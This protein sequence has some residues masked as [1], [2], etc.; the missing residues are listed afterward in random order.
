VIYQDSGIIPQ[1]VKQPVQV[2]VDWLEVGGLDPLGWVTRWCET[3]GSLL[4][5]SAQ[6]VGEGI[7]V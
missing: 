5:P 7:H 4:W 2:K 3:K 6:R 1:G